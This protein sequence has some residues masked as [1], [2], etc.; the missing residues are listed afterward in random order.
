MRIF[1]LLVFLCLAPLS[2]QQAVRRS[3]RANGDGSVSVRPDAARV[4]VSVVK[5]AATAAD[6]AAQNATT[7]AAVIAAIR[8]LL[9]PNADVR[10]AFYNL[11]PIYSTPR[12]GPQQIV[13]FTATNTIEAVAADPALGGRVI[14]TAIASGASRVDSVRLFLRDEEPSRAQALRVASQRARSRA[15]AIALG[16]GVRLGQILNVQEGTPTVLAAGRIDVGATATTTPIEGGTLE[17]RAN[18]VLEI[19]IAP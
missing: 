4:S 14:D 7:A 8:Q 19:E 11:S 6:A 13:G 10:T 1:S 15:D 2:A 18:V 16:L 12:D 9:G 3:V 5:Q 17:V